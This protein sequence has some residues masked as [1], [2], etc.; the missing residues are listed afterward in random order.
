MTN[1]PRTSIAK[2]FPFTFRPTDAISLPKVTSRLVAKASTTGVNLGSIERPSLILLLFV[3][4]FMGAG[5]SQRPE[6]PRCRESVEF[7]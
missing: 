4:V 3:A 2:I 5:P 6:R 1:C 7:A